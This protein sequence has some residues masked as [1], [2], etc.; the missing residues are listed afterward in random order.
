[1]YLT[2]SPHKHQYPSDCKN[3]VGIQN[4]LSNKSFNVTDINDNLKSNNLIVG[5]LGSSLTK[6]LKEPPVIWQLHKCYLWS[7]YTINHHSLEY[8]SC[9]YEVGPVRYV[10][11]TC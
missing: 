11:L 7:K 3:L 10:L 1:M 4:H 6:T 8:Y 2:M 9:Q 5:V